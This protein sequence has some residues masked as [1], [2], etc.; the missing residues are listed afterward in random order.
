[1]IC[2]IYHNCLEVKNAPMSSFD[3]ANVVGDVEQ[4]G[5]SFSLPMQFLMGPGDFTIDPNTLHHMVY[6]SMSFYPVTCISTSISPM[7]SMSSY[8]LQMDTTHF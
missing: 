8:G 4:M 2:R 7:A 3:I 5:M 1:V 6:P